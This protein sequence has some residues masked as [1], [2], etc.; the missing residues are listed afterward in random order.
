[1]FQ[2]EIYA[3]I[4]ILFYYFLLRYKFYFILKFIKNYIF[5][6]HSTKFKLIFYYKEVFNLTHK[7]V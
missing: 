4:R 5:N 1:M 7:F 3:C 2:I 6:D